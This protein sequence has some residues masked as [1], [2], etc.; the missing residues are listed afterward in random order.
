MEPTTP[1]LR[2]VCTPTTPESPSNSK[3]DLESYFD[4]E[5]NDSSASYTGLPN[6][7]AS[8]NGLPPTPAKTPKKRL[9]PS[10]LRERN[11]QTNEPIEEDAGNNPFLGPPAPA[12]VIAK[13][14]RE[15][16]V[17]PSDGLFY[18]FRGKKVKK[19]FSEGTDLS[20]LKPRR[21]FPEAASSS[22][23]TPLSDR[24]D[25]SQHPHIGVLPPE[26]NREQKSLYGSSSLF[27]PTTAT[28]T[29]LPFRNRGSHPP[30]SHT[31]SFSSGRTR[32]LPS[33]GR[34]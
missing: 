7:E 19:V 15:M 22:S 23:A 14:K 18:I 17:P 2:P 16:E 10:L 9:F 12:E 33:A 20:S 6:A 25:S 30:S 11:N 3:L 5:A 26:Y 13:R 8:C 34:W 28:A 31:S 21:L 4:S 1:P 29:S 32:Q 27:G 24:I